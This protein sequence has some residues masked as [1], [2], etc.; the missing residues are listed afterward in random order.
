MCETEVCE[1]AIQTYAIQSEAKS[2]ALKRGDLDIGAPWSE[3]PF[4]RDGVE[5]QNNF[6]N[7]EDIIHF[8]RIAQV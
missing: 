6:L 5:H 7:P 1:I 8:K 2:S 3:T 4:P